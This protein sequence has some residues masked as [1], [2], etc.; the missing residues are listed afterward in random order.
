MNEVEPK[1]R[2]PKIDALLYA[3]TGLGALIVIASWQLAPT[4][5]I[6]WLVLGGV[7]YLGF[8][9]PRYQNWSARL[10]RAR[11]A[12]KRE[13]EKWGFHS[14]DREGPW[15]NYV[16]FPLIKETDIAAGKFFYSEWLIIH[17]G[18]IVVNPGPAQIHGSPAGGDVEYDFSVRRAYAWDGCTPK[19]WFF[20]LA[21]FGTPDWSE[22]AESIVSFDSAGKREPKQ[23]FWQRAHHASLVHDALYQYLDLIPIA[24]QDV[25]NLFHD[26]LKV[27]GLHPW[28]AKLYHLAVR[29]FGAREIEENNPRPNTTLRL[30]NVPVFLNK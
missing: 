27:S 7:I 21:L 20:W 6:L 2:R 8:G 12:K 29:Y 5:I 16:D 9:L 14:R 25:D 3:M 1:L 28:L 24:K 30:R 11:K 13:L 15:L 22:N 4:L 18:A 23:M 10:E 17:D 26:M 19:R